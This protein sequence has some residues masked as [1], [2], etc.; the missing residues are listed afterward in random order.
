MW[1]ADLHKADTA[2]QLHLSQWYYQLAL[3]SGINWSWITIET[4]LKK[5]AIRFAKPDKSKIFM[6]LF[7]L[8]FTADFMNISVLHCKVLQ[9][10]FDKHLTR[11][12]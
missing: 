12:V 5:E 6:F 7:Q 3:N 8:F 1:S 9:K 2:P 10:Y 4:F 11:V